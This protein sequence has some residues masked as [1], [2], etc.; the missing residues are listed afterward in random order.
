MPYPGNQNDADIMKTII[1]DPNGLCKFLRTNDV[2]VLDRGFRD[3]V[4]DLEENNFKVLIPA[5][6]GK[7]KQLPT[8]E[9][10]QSRFVTKI[11]W[12]VESDHGMLK[13][14]YRLLDHKIDNKLLPN[15]RIYFRVGIIS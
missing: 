14:K 8:E 3:V 1:E 5:L 13:Q 15:T 12:L 11:R 2:F 4:K 6:K 7:R 9:S 10:N